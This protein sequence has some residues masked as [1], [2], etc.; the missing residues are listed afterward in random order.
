MIYELE[1][2]DAVAPKPFVKLYYI[3]QA[4]RLSVSRAGSVAGHFSPTFPIQN[5]P[6]EEE[7][8]FYLRKVYA[9]YEKALLAT[10]G[11]FCTYGTARESLGEGM[12]YYEPQST[13][14]IH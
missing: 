12:N 5:K 13:S 11:A 1:Q 2:N 14:Q 3:F 7:I 10:V 9:S 4:K 6:L 8:A